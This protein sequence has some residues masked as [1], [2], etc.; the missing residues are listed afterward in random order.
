[1][2]E[3]RGKYNARK[4]EIDGHKFDSAAEARRYQDLK[5]AEKAGEIRDLELQHKFPLV[6]NDIK[7]GIYLCDFI[8]R[9]VSSGRVVV[10][11]VKGYRKGGA[12]AMFRLK[13]KL[14]SAIYGIKI[15]EIE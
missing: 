11:D 10:E 13:A 5:L 6:V 9:E 4:V 7:V 2:S 1:M 8:Y 14:V 12:Y 15:T 3:R